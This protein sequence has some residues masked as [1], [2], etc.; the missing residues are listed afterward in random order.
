[1]IVR[2]FIPLHTMSPLS[3]RPPPLCHS[4]PS[5]FSMWSIHSFFQVQCKCHQ[6]LPQFPQT[7]DTRGI[8]PEIYELNVRAAV[9]LENKPQNGKGQQELRCEL[10]S[11]QWERFFLGGLYEQRGYWWMTNG[12]QLGS[13]DVSQN[14]VASGC[15]FG[16][17]PV[18][19]WKRVP[20]TSRAGT[21][22]YS[23]C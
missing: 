9:D 7:L 16:E 4:L 21:M 14:F 8:E 20:H 2:T 5:T 19:L 12:W 3:G 22:P 11:G 10:Q 23:S 6:D 13:W 15:I 17:T 1:M 18:S